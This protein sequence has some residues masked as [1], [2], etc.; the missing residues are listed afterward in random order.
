[1]IEAAATKPYGYMK[2][3]PGPGLGGHC[4]PIDPTYLSWKMKA[5]NFPARFIELAT[6]INSQMPAHVVRR[7]GDILNGDRLA[8]KG[9]RLLLVGVAYKPNVSDVRE[10]PA[11]E[12]AELLLHKGAAVD[13]HDPHV[14]EL[15]VGAHVLKSVDLTDDV[16]GAT[17]LVLIVTDHAGID[18][19][20]VV[21][22]ASRIFDT[23]NATKQVARGREKIQ[24]L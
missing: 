10:S 11:L 3:L 22:R 18:Y 4:I 20:R 12:I 14:P 24:K 15:H 9:S 5:L 1:V 17:D 19:Q 16:L 21:D 8:V 6:E 2:F 7:V 13:Y 23:R